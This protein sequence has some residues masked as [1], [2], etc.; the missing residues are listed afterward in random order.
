MISNFSQNR[1]VYALAAL[2]GLTVICLACLGLTSLAGLAERV[3]T[4]PATVVV[5]RLA[6]AGAEPALPAAEPATPSPTPTEI[7]EATATATASP[8]PTLPPT[9]TPEPTPSAPPL[10]ILSMS[11]Y[12]DGIDYLH[13]V[14][15][16]EN[17]SEEPFEFVQVLVTLYDAGGKV[18]NTDFTYTD[19]DIVLPGQKA[20]FGV[21]I[22]EY[23]GT[24]E[25]VAQVQGQPANRLPYPDLRVVNTSEF[26][27]SI[28]Y[29]HLVGE[30]VNEG[31]RS[32]T[33]VK[34]VATLYNDAGEVVG[35][36]FTY[37]DL[38]TVPAGGRSPFELTV[39]EEIQFTTYMVQVQGQVE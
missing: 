2:G 19:L 23:T 24:V 16:I 6:P 15:E 30:V 33:F 37:A 10:E 32:A 27:D 4:A 28:N 38:D 13:V 29:W 11:D 8:E 36:D 22:A 14:G 7:P 9:A 25:Y 1:I 39:N 18:V 17:K 20:P 31:S 35:T 34:I 5:D 26:V 12:V 21:A 3:P